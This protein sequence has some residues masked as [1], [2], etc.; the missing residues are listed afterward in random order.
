MN[1]FETEDLVDSIGSAWYRH[2]HKNAVSLRDAL[3][4]LSLRTTLYRQFEELIKDLSYS[5]DPK[6]YDIHVPFTP[7]DIN[8]KTINDVEHYGVVYQED[9]TPLSVQN[10]EDFVLDSGYIYFPEKLEV[11]FPE[12]AF[13]ILEAEHHRPS[14]YKYILD[15]ET[16]YENID[17]IMDYFKNGMDKLSFQQA[18]YS[19]AKLPRLETAEKTKLMNISEDA[20]VTTYTFE[21]KEELE[22]DYQ[23]RKLSLFQSYDRTHMF[24]GEPLNFHT[25][26]HGSNDN[27]YRVM[28]WSYGLS[29]DPLTTYQNLIVPPFDVYAYAGGMD[30]DSKNGDK[31]HARFQLIGDYAQQTEFWEA[32]AKRETLSKNYLNQV[33]GLPNEDPVN[34]LANIE[35]ATPEGL[36][37]AIVALPD[38]TTVNP[39]DLVMKYFL[40]DVAFI[41]VCNRDLVENIDELFTWIKKHQPLGIVPIN[42]VEKTLDGTKINID[43]VLEPEFN[44]VKYLEL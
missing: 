39:L 33:I 10:G 31:V 14:I 43:H 12:M 13:I 20:G 25:K 30:Y 1:F 7:E 26:L 42:R 35:A 2:L 36:D 34:N 17:F 29:L 11:R 8:I 19:I 18:I 22:I 32:V 44:T 41:T 28:D 21:N 5:K 27:W 6:I 23:H 15:T 40:G 38:K 37:P 3:L 24:L 16:P 4:N 9:I